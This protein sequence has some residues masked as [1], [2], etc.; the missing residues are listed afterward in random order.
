METK[1]KL[2]DDLNYSDL[3]QDEISCIKQRL[4]DD[5]YFN[6]YIPGKGLQF[7]LNNY[8]NLSSLGVL[9]KNWME[10]YTHGSHFND[11]AL[12]TL[13][14]IFDLCS[15]KLLQVKYPIYVGDHFSNGKRFS[16]FRGCAGIDHR[17]GMSWTSSLDRAIWYA[18]HH[19]EHYSL[20]NVA[21]YAAVVQRDEIYCCGS[22]YDHDFV[23]KF[24]FANLLPTYSYR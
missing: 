6:R 2:V 4:S 15:K 12:E 3:N 1:L 11:T 24:A 10:A 18:A 14:S 17:M 5:G 9:E 21:V 20:T 7:I 8:I 23:S 22:H 16:L 13:K 19:A